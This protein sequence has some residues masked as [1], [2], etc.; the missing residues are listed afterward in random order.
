MTL[1]AVPNVSEGRDSGLVNDMTAAVTD[2]G[3]HLLD[4]HSDPAHNRSV[5]TCAGD[6][7]LLVASM[8]RLAERCAAVDLAKHSGAHPRLG[9]LDVCPF[10][11]FDGPMSEAVGAAVEA[12]ERI[13]ERV[14]APVFLYGAAA[15]REATRDLPRLRSGGLGGLARRMD[16]GLSP[17]FGPAK[18]DPHV[19]VICVGARGPLIAF[20]VWF[21]CGVN[22][23]E[24]IARSI[25]SSRGGPPGVRALGL[26]MTESLSQVSMNLVEPDVTGIDDAYELVATRARALEVRPTA[27]EIVGLVHDKWLPDPQKETA[28]L[29]L[30]PGRSIESALGR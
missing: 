28:R 1:V 10:V 11:P 29:L 2:A 5:L 12:A 21:E 30:K 25:R 9:V 23:V 20:N 15:L 17:D 7:E 4:V 16:V 27:T 14:G 13:A 22:V 8:A 3:A 6:R 18:I 24:E 26:K 19:G